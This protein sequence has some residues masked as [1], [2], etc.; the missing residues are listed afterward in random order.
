MT[1]PRCAALP[2]ATRFLSDDFLAAAIFAGFELDLGVLPAFTDD[3][4]T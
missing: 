2:F 4:D 3:L 1:R